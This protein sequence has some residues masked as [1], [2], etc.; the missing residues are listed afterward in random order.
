MGEH[1]VVPDGRVDQAGVDV[2][3]RVR[4]GLRQVEHAEQRRWKVPSATFVRRLN[5]DQRAAQRVSGARFEFHGCPPSGD[6][7]C[8]QVGADDDAVGVGDAHRR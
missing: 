3:A 1:R 4:V 5:I 8:R 6:E 2:Y 7:L